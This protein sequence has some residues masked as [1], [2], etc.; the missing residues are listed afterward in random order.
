MRPG[1]GEQP[2]GAGRRAPGSRAGTRGGRPGFRPTRQNF[3]ASRL[4]HPNRASA[5]VEKIN[6]NFGSAAQVTPQGAR[7]PGVLPV[8]LG[9]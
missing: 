2:R 7:R 1:G 4:P 3:P 8:L 6:F 5:T 9:L